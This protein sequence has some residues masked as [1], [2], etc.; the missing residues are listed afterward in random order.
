VLHGTSDQNFKGSC[1]CGVDEYCLCTPSLAIDA[2]IEVLQKGS[3]DVYIALVFRRDPPS[4]YYAI[5]GGFVNVGETVESAAIR[6]VKEETNLDLDKLEQF[7]VYS[8]PKRDSRRHTASVVFRCTANNVSRIHGGDDA[9]RVEL[10]KLR[11]A[12]AL[13]LA[14]DHYQIITEYIRHYHPS[15]LMDAI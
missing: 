11:S 2:I 5:P 15:L 13:R 4:S 8:D 14:F 10:V 12:L 6:E 1:Y 9:K 3:Q 7:R